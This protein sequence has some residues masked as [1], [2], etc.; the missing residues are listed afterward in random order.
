[1]LCVRRDD[2]TLEGNSWLCSVALS[3]SLLHHGSPAAPLAEL[4]HT[5]TSLTSRS[6]ERRPAV[7][8]ALNSDWTEAK[9]GLV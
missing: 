8:S 3:S 6:S 5:N 1:M 9:S 2:V 4:T 7:C